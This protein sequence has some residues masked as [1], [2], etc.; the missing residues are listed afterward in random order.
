MGP[1]P[2]NA[3][4]WRCVHSS[5]KW[6][7]SLVDELLISTTT[8]KRKQ[9][10][11]NLLSRWEVFSYMSSIFIFGPNII[12]IEINKWMFISLTSTKHSHWF[13]VP[14]LR[15]CLCAWASCPWKSKG[16]FPFGLDM[17]CQTAL[18]PRSCAHTSSTSSSD[19]RVICTASE[20]C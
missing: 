1:A 9:S 12:Y 4:A 7:L 18:L 16:I 20:V 2:W 11:S 15:P 14:N 13:L 8:T 17:H 19:S 5:L 6:K 3:W 10:T